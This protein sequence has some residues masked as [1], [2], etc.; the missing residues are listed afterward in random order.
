MSSALKRRHST[1][2]EYSSLKQLLQE[3]S[4]IAPFLK[5]RKNSSLSKI[6]GGHTL[7][8]LA[9]SWDISTDRLACH[10]IDEEE[11]GAEREG[12]SG[13]ESCAAFDPFKTHDKTSAKP[14]KVQSAHKTS[15]ARPPSALGQAAAASS[16][17]AA[18]SKTPRGF[19]TQSEGQKDG[20]ESK[21]PTPAPA[22]AKSRQDID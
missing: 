1:Q 21:I 6:A 2:R 16:G 11:K 14:R 4:L 10:V 8:E 13:E 9:E 5:I 12:D 20:K 17:R 3:S 22:R 7:I 19:A 15:G 18:P